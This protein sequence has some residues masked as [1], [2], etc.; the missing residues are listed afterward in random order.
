MA[1]ESGAVGKT[2]PPRFS[3]PRRS[4]SWL[5]GSY[6][7]PH[8]SNLKPSYHFE[9]V[10]DNR[11]GRNYSIPIRDVHLTIAF[12]WFT[13][14]SSR[15]MIASNQFALASH[16]VTI[17]SSQYVFASH[18]FTIASSRF[19]VASNQFALASHRLTIASNQ[20]ALA[21]SR[22]VLASMEAIVIRYNCLGE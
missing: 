16:R 4:A 3:K 18:R 5:F 22:F 9:P 12:R 7:F 13:I 19:V 1:M 11:H 10:S 6:R 20:F 2:R 17:A 14:A 8:T 21:S 15:F